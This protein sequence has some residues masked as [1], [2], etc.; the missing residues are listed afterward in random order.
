MNRRFFSL[1]KSYALKDKSWKRYYF[2]AVGIRSDGRIVHSTN[3]RNPDQTPECHAETRLTAKLDVGSE[4]YVVRLNKNGK[5]I[6]LARP[7]DNCVARMRAKGVHTVYYSISDTE[8]GQMVF[9]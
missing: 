7:C 9:V 6:L 3:L 1:A 2:G 4:V 5:R 8:F